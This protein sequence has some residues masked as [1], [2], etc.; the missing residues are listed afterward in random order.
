MARGKRSTRGAKKPA[1]GVEE[2][3]KVPALPPLGADA[4]DDK[5]DAAPAAKKAKVDDAQATSATDFRGGQES[6]N[7]MLYQLL[8]YKAQNGNFDVPP[9]ASYRL[10]RNWAETQRKHYALY[11]EDRTSGT[12][13]NA[14]RIA[15]L[16]AIGFQWNVAGDMFWEANFAA[17]AA[18]K[19]EHGDVKVP[20]VYAKNPKLAEWV[21][22]QR[23][24]WKARGEGKP[25]ILTDE[26]TA[27]LD[28]LGMVWKV[29]DR[30]DW[31][32]RY[33]QLLEFK[34]ENGHCVV[35]QH[36]ARNRPLGK[37]VAKQREQ[38]RFY[39]EGKHSF[40][41][42]ERIDLL[43]SVGFVWKIKGRKKA[44]PAEEAS[45]GAAKSPFGEAPRSLAKAEKEEEEATKGGDAAAALPPAL[46]AAVKAEEALAKAGDKKMPPLSQEQLLQASMAAIASQASG[47]SQM[48]DIAAALRL[49]GAGAAA[50]QAGETKGTFV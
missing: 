2:D 35:P 50:A 14:D 39:R 12:F 33:E 24:Q 46:A 8:L 48:A 47:G 49:G 29:R 41:T 9:D 11:Q 32:D 15:V 45:A 44:V 7:A 28:G 42:E 22:E 17:L 19:A 23:R 31:N 18:Y 27:Q 30:A 6:W 26:R 37:W 5:D 10:L 16:D 34:K 38:Y 4:N 20:R 21:T 36:Y 1:A 25:H 40:L 3:P 43:K 13:L